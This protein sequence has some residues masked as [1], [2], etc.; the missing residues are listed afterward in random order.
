MNATS[1][2]S[3]ALQKLNE[4]DPSLFLDIQAMQETGQAVER[5]MVSARQHDIHIDAE[6]LTAQLETLKTLQALFRLEPAAA[7]EIHKTENPE[8]N[9]QRIQ[10]LAQAQ[11]MELD[12]DALATLLQNATA[13]KTETE[14]SDAELAN[15]SGGVTPSVIGGLLNWGIRLGLIRDPVGPALIGA[16][17][18]TP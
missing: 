2:I 17:R 9:S 6:T 3:A 15:V 5:I 14:L 18:N 10:A 7:N 12:P 1:D 11:G 13:G 16:P 4:N 8:Q